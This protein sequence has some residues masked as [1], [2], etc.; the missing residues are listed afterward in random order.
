MADSVTYRPAT[1]ED[2]EAILPHL[3]PADVAECEALTGEGT[4]RA[5]AFGTLL[6]S[7]RAWT[8]EVNGNPVAMFGVAGQMINAV[9]HPWMFGTPRMERHARALISEGRTYIRTMLSVF[10]RLENVVD[11]RNTKS[12]RWLKR[13][14]FRIR[15]PM[16]MGV[17]GLPFHPFDMEV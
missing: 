14:G 11:A 16:V 12:I 5:A 6:G 10:P 13:L 17:A 15:P 7:V 3:R 1:F 4:L 2:V 9:G 8:A